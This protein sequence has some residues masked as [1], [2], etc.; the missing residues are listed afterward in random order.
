MS[1][2]TVSRQFVLSPAPGMKVTVIVNELAYVTLEGSS[3]PIQTFTV[4]EVGGTASV[5]QVFTIHNI[6]EYAEGEL[7]VASV[8]DGAP[9][10]AYCHVDYFLSGAT[11]WD[12]HVLKDDDPS[13][14]ASTS[15]TNTLA[16]AA[17]TKPSPGGVHS[18]FQ[19]LDV[20]MVFLVDKH[21]NGNMLFRGNSPM[22]EAKTDNG[23]QRI[24]FDTLHRYLEQRYKE[25]TGLA[26]FPQKG[27]YVLCDVCLQ[28]PASEGGAIAEELK[29]FG[30]DN[31]K[32]L[33]GQAWYP[34]APVEKDGYWVQMCNWS[35]EPDGVRTS[36]DDLF[37]YKMAMDLSAWIDGRKPNDKPHIYY[38][39][40]A[41]GHDRTGIAASTYLIKNRM[42]G[43][44]E[45]FVYGTTVAK[46]PK[47]PGRSQ[48]Q[49]N[50]DDMGT[51]TLDPDRSRIM[52]ISDV[53]NET[54][55]NIYT[56]M[57]PKSPDP[58][59]SP[60]STSTDPAYVYPNYPWDGE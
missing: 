50:C 33:A 38:I 58:A 10:T 60:A 40:C 1:N 55:V 28:S 34:S 37:D 51:S 19:T 14:I 25:Q 35:I 29:S 21:S 42:L 23:P 7:S 16:V 6:S 41:S 13:I 47:G 27:D 48:L 8:V 54:V 57:N 22:A 17:P 15:L 59:L 11:F 45:A 4:G 18:L 31:L 30:G 3:S 20:A 44:S 9:N 39:H 56:L 32:Q 53:Y 12:R 49:R 2:T 52:L 36:Q 24:D 46:L 5:T 26:D 43:L